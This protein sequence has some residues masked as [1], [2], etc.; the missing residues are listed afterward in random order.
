VQEF[1]DFDRG[2]AVL[3]LIIRNGVIVQIGSYGVYFVVVDDDKI[4][5]F[6]HCCA[7]SFVRNGAQFDFVDAV[8]ARSGVVAARK[9]EEA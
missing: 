4:L 6:A 8:V 9:A 5:K 3:D 2:N 7:V 1:F